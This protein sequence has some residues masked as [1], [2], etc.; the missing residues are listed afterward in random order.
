MSAI[1]EAK[2]I[3]LD[4]DTN[5]DGRS[6][7]ANYRIKVHKKEQIAIRSA[8]TEKMGVQTVDEFDTMNLTSSLVI[9][10]FI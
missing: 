7:K 5:G 9:S 4:S 10:T 2:G 1:L 6:S 3:S 8:Y